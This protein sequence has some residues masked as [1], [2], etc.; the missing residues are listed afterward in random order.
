MSE[1]DA[2]SDTVTATVTRVTPTTASLGNKAL[3]AVIGLWTLLLFVPLAP[4]VVLVWLWN[5]FGSDDEY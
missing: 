4:F 5:R 2:E 1:T 3:D